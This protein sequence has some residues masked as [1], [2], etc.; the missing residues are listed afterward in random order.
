MSC[1]FNNGNIL[2]RTVVCVWYRHIHVEE[3]TAGAR[4]RVVLLDANS[5]SDKVRIGR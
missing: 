2:G 5:T 4:V 3:R 1:P